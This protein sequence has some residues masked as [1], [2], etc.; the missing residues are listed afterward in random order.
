MEQ[1]EIN[2][3]G[4]Q[5]PNNDTQQPNNSTQE[6]INDIQGS[7]ND[8]QE[9]NNDPQKPINATQESNNSNQETNNNSQEANN[10]NQEKD[11]IVKERN[12]TIE[13]DFIPKGDIGD[14]ILTDKLV[15]EKDQEKF[16][17]KTCSMK[18]GSV[19]GG[20]F[21][22]SSLA[23]GPGAFSLPIRCTQLG[24]IWYMI[25]IVFAAWA[26]YWTLSGMIRSARTVR[27]EDYSPSVK[28]IIGKPAGKLVDIT[29]ILYLYVIFI[30]YQVII[31]SLIGRTIYELFG[32]KDK[33]VNFDKYESEVWDAAKLKYPIM[34][35]I[36]FLMTPI[37]LLKDISKMRFASM[38]GIVAYIYCISVI[39]IESPWFLKH[40]LKNYKEDDPS[41]HANF[42]DITK[43]FDK[44]LNF[45]TGMATVFFA[46]SC[47]AAA[48][49]IY[50]SLNNNTE[51]RINKVFFTSICIDIIIYLLIA[52]CGFITAP[53]KPE[54]LV[55]FR[56]SVFE[57]DIFMTIAKI[58]LAI[59]LFLSLP[60][61]YA[62]YRI[63]FFIFFFGTDKIDTKRNLIVTLVTLYTT[64]LIGALYKDILAYISFL[65]GFCCSIADYLIPGVMIILTSKE[66]ITSRM[67]IIRCIVIIVLNTFGF[68]GGLQTIR[69]VIQGTN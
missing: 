20:I 13:D 68:M 4:N 28:L 6:P 25:L 15:D 16:E 42:Y 47:Q 41:T 48:F 33:Y 36:I 65:G 52:V 40:Y 61:N 34:F 45:F 57:N 32:D 9:P 12:T 1:G 2:E 26:T 3:N 62:G 19:L 60:A 38:F 37:C 11:N 49:P 23:L 51:K 46:Y 50:K 66:K 18:E 35:G 31:Y 21:A 8:T 5:E 43:G 14:L 69:S 27:G 24:L 64:T 55:I 10:G 44:N 56:E 22:I 63:S 7:I 29:L 53:L 30:Q 67:N 17:E 58:S 54:S 59:N 39:V